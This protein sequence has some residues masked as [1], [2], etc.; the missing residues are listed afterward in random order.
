MSYLIRKAPFWIGG[1]L[2]LVGAEFR[3][4]CRPMHRSKERTLFDYLVC[5]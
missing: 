5:A 1:L 2:C 3:A 4:S